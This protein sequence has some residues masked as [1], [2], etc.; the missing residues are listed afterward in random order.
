LIRSEQQIISS[1]DKDK[2]IGGLKSILEDIKS[3]IFPEQ[4]YSDLHSEIKSIDTLIRLT[5]RASGNPAQ[6]LQ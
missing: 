5:T 2:I 3:G 1:D 6:V 4:L